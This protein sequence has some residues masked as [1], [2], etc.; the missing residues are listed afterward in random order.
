MGH[1][2]DIRTGPLF[3]MS[4]AGHASGPVGGESPPPVLPQMQYVCFMGGIEW[5]ASGNGNMCQGVGAETQVD[6][7]V[8]VSVNHGGGLTGL[9]ETL[10]DGDG[11][12][13][14]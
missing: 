1:D 11:V 9:Q 3:A 4:C 12:Q 14:P 10:G 5:D 2:S 6:E 7:G 13:V 8:G